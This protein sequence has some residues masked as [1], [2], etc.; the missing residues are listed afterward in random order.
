MGTTPRKL[1]L[2][3]S[4]DPRVFRSTDRLLPLIASLRVSSRERKPCPTNPSTLEQSSD[5]IAFKQMSGG[6][7]RLPFLHNARFLTAFFIRSL[8]GFFA[9]AVVALIMRHE[10]RTL[11]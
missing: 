8:V 3:Q 4:S 1:R 9:K 11:L 5:D 10:P 6:R 2:K 7:A